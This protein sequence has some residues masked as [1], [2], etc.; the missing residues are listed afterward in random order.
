MALQNNQKGKWCCRHILVVSLI[1]LTSLTSSIMADNS[2]SDIQITLDAT[3]VNRKI[4]HSSITINDG[5]NDVSL[6]YPKWIPGLHGPCGPISNVARFKVVDNSGAPVLWERDYADAFRFN[7]QG[8]ANRYP[9]TVS[10]SYIVNQPTSLSWG[11]DCASTATLGVLNWNTVSIYPEGSVARDLKVSPRLI[12]PAGWKYA[13]AM[14]VK[15]TRGDTVLFETVTYEELIDFPVICGLY[16]KTFKL[17]TKASAD[18]FIHFVVDEE[19]MLPFTDSAMA[20]QGWGKLV[21][22]AATMF[23]R[24]HYDSYHFLV[25]ISNSIIHYGLEHRNSSVNSLDFK[26]LKGYG[27]TRYSLQGL[28]AHEFVHAWCGKYRRP[29]GMSTPDYQIPK[30]RQLLWVYEGLTSYLGMVLEARSGLVS[31]DY[32]RADIAQYWGNLRRKTGREWRSIKDIAISNHTVWEGSDSWAFQRRSADYYPEGAFLWLEVDA[33]IR[34]ATNGKQSLNDFCQ[35]LF[36]TSE[37]TAHSIPYAQSDLVSELNELVVFDWDSLFNSKISG[38]SDKLDETP[39]EEAGY[40][41][42]FTAKKPKP[43]ANYESQNECHY[44]YESIGFA[45]E[46]EDNMVLQ[47]IPGTPG[48]E[49]GIY[50]RM[51]ILGVNGKTFSFDRMD[52]AITDATKTGLITLLTQHGEELK[53]LTINYSDGLR[54][55]ELQLIEGRKNWLDEIMKPV[56]NDI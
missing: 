56:N 24:E 6:L 3:E 32:H 28:L 13:T 48:D 31:K 43:I 27:K 44:Y 50:T 29:I 12:L 40:R 14:P 37:I 11:S 7:I 4:V 39:L 41:L 47:V 38:I 34:N 22:E 49:A 54:Y 45:V 19:V 25:P 53:E 17:E 9:L 5:D 2:T 42:Q 18:Y 30:N 1:L 23:G 21:D 33:R 35:S 55:F 8:A 16:L 15:E 52:K 46:E 10:L 51:K 36:G 26:A 20:D